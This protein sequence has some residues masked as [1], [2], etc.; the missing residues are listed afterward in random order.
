MP[1]KLEWLGYRMVKKNYDDM[2]SRFHPI[3]GRHEQTDGQTELLY[4]YRT[5]VCWRAI[6]TELC[7]GYSVQTIAQIVKTL[8]DSSSW[9]LPAHSRQYIVATVANYCHNALHST[10]QCMYE[11]VMWSQG[12]NLK[13]STLE[14]NAPTLESMAVGPEAEAFSI[15][16]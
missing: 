14:A 4:Q 5:S 10:M 11:P 7:D 1:V 3:P 6:K 13:A 9:N 8:V 15:R 12:Q 2:L 16:P